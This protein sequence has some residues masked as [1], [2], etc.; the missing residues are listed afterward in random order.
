MSHEPVKKSAKKSP[1]KAKKAKSP[2]KAKPSKIIIRSGKVSQ[3]KE[4]V[5]QGKLDSFF[6]EINKESNKGNIQ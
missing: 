3:V 4:S 2:E 6:K 5:G 1:K